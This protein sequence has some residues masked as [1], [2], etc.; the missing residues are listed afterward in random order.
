MYIKTQNL[1]DEQMK[2]ISVI[3]VVLFV[4]LMPLMLLLTDAQ[5]LAYDMD[6][7]RAEYVKYGIPEYIGMSMD[8]LMDSTEKL[9]QYLDNKRA[10]LNFKASFTN[11]EE[12][13]FSQRDK[14]HMVDVK[15]LFV[16]GRF[17]RDASFF[18]ITCFIMLAI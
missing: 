17:F 1:G 12:E 15:G 10:D 14:Y 5:L 2:K 6:Y 4:V 11:G 9:L 18:Y 8:N 13:F 16:K 7:Y 3:F